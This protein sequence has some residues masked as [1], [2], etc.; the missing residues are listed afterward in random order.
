MAGIQKLKQIL[1][2]QR[3]HVI[4][5]I[6]KV[7][8]STKEDEPVKATKIL[9]NSLIKKK[10]VLEKCDESILELLTEDGD[11]EKEIEDS[12]V[13]ADR[14]I[15]A[16][17]KLEL[18]LDYIQRK[19]SE[20]VSPKPEK[21]RS[22]PKTESQIKLPKIPLNEYAGSLVSWNNFWSQYDVAVHKN[23]D[24]SV[25]QKFTYLKS[26]LTGAAERSIQGL[27]L[28]QENYDNAVEILLSRFGNKQMRITAHMNELRNL[29]RV[30]TLNNTLDMRKM[31]EILEFNINNLK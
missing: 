11:V 29:K 13:F 19:D 28:V 17:T 12:S 25:V 10:K 20:S 24:L 9:L 22:S 31:F 3:T 8:D 2:R 21:P 1:N 5:L 7:K 30:D 27:T 18:S 6:D 26:F 23:K 4:K 16:T 14:I 15:E